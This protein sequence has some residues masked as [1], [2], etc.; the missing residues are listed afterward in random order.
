MELYFYAIE[1]G[2]RLFLD[3]LQSSLGDV[4]VESCDVDDFPALVDIVSVS[5]GE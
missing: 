4:A 2:F 5:W 3:S 1:E